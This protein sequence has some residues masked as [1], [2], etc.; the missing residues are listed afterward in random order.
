MASRIQAFSHRGRICSERKRRAVVVDDTKRR[1]DGVAARWLAVTA[2]RF[3][4]HCAVDANFP[5]AIVKSVIGYVDVELPTR[6]AGWNRNGGRHG[7][8]LVRIRRREPDGY[9]L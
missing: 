4:K 3:D 5:I 2:T 7:G 8:N 6:R 1:R 9:R